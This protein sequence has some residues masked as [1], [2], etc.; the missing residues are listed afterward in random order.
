MRNAFSTVAVA[1]ALLIAIPLFHNG[2][3]TG[4][5]VVVAINALA[6]TGLGLLVGAAGEVSLAQAAFMGVGAYA[7]AI[8]AGHGWNT[9]LAIVG[10]AAIAV[11]L[12]ALVG[13]P[14]LRLRG[15]YLTLATLG[16]GIIFFVFLNE[17]SSLTGGPS[18][19]GDYPA[20]Q[21]GTLKLSGDLAF[22]VLAWSCVLLAAIGSAALRGSWRGRALRA[23]AASEVAASSVGISVRTRKLEA[24]ILSAIAASI[25]GSIYAFYVGF[26]SP[27]TF[28]F[29]QS[30]FLLV[31]VVLGGAERPTGP[32]L[33]AVLFIA[34]NEA[35]QALG[36]HLFPSSAQSAVAALQIV[37]FGIV[38]IAVMRLLPQGVAGAWFGRATR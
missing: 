14:T 2:F 16:L 11:V 1:V 37:A 29:E 31:M 24:F 28:G 5:L 20:L 9:W 23:I 21:I 15:H 34:V 12:A 35:L 19:Y 30:V 33:G 4:I 7:T 17:A 38:L 3:V 25:A 36:S 27:T 26:V 18:G 10:A 13:Y 6:A 32:V 8:L 22:Y